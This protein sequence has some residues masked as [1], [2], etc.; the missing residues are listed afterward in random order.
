[1]L[2]MGSPG[3]D[4]HR[5]GLHHLCSYRAWLNLAPGSWRGGN[6]VCMYIVHAVEGRILHGVPAY[7]GGSMPTSLSSLLSGSQGASQ[8]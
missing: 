2:G 4:L 3:R 5:K 1:M 7:A 6:E 8:T